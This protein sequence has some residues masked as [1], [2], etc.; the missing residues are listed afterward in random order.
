M[1]E[2]TSIL[3]L[4]ALADYLIADPEYNF[5]PVRIIGYIISKIEC[6]L[7][8]IGLNAFG[9]G[10]LLLLF[11]NV[12]VITIISSIYL[13]VIFTNHILSL[14]AV[15]F[16]LYSAIGFKSLLLYAN[17]IYLQIKNNE[18]YKA[19]KTLINIVGRDVT[20]LNEE[21]IVKATIESVAENFVDGFLSPIF[22]FCI[23]VFVGSFGELQLLLGIVFAYIYRVTNTLDSMVGYRNKKYELFGKASAKFDDLLNYITAR[24]SIPIISLAAFLINADWKESIGIAIQDRLKHKSPNSAHPESAVAG[25][26]NVKLGGATYYSFGIVE[27]KWLGEKFNYPKVNDL[28]RAVK[29]ITVSALISLLI[30]I[31]IMIVCT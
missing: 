15:A 6:G 19:R 4:A 13:F 25:A 30:G 17:K 5:H 9:G 7:Y 28:N 2:A 24:A 27:K 23:G 18:I 29:L 21:E 20:S 1:I 12:I 14:F 16:F 10:V 22:W 11:S 26:L 31:C 8:S 3:L